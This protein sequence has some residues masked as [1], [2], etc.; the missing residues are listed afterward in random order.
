MPRAIVCDFIIAFNFSTN[1]HRK[2]TAR[3]F[4]AGSDCARGRNDQRPTVL[5]FRA[6]LC[7]LAFH[8]R[9]SLSEIAFRPVERLGGT[10]G[11]YYGNWLWSLR[12][13]IDLAVGGPGMRRGRRDPEH[14]LPGDTIDCWRVEAVP[15]GRLLRLSP[16]MRLPGRAWLSIRAAAGR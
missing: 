1:L 15:A 5:K 16:E 6:P 11:W 13:L 9:A 4:L 10:T 2:I 12:G 14:L 8:A 7:R 3:E